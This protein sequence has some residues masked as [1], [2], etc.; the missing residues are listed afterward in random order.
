MTRLPLA[1]L[2]ALAVSAAAIAG[3]LPA[4]SDSQAGVTVTVTPRSLAG[5]VWE[6]DVALNTHSQDLNDD[7]AKSAVLVGDGGVQV[8]ASGWQGDPP[9]GHH[10]KGVLR[11]AA[12][13][14]VPAAIELRVARPG[15]QA[16]R[17]FRWKLR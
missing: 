1:F 17:A 16:P 3:G 7:L 14:P 4:R 9:G 6:F 10:R 15:E 11:F 5:Q 8:A 13:S 2:A 12:P